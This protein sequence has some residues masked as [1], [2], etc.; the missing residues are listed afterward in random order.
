MVDKMNGYEQTI[1]FLIVAYIAVYLLTK[2]DIIQNINIIEIIYGVFVF[3]ISLAIVIVKC[4]RKSYK[5]AGI[6]IIWLL[7]IVSIYILDPPVFA[8]S[9]FYDSKSRDDALSK[10][11]LQWDYIPN[12]NIVRLKDVDMVISEVYAE[13]RSQWENYNMNKIVTLDGK[14][15]I[16]IRYKYYNKTNHQELKNRKG[17]DIASMTF[18]IRN[19]ILVPEI[20]VSTL[21][22]EDTLC[23]VFAKHTILKADNTYELINPID[24]IY[25]YPQL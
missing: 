23:L 14:P 17:V 3:L 20:V 12:K 21:T 24:T 7:P 6:M 10:E 2:L 13:K 25:M 22:Q 16:R 4:L 5:Q 1:R 19:K 9:L 8:Q 15:K 11:I 18:V